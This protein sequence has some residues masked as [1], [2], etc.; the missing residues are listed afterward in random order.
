M[1]GHHPV[2]TLAPNL[3]RWSASNTGVD[4]VHERSGAAP[5]PE[6][7][8]TALVHGNEY[9]GAIALAE[10]LAA[11]WRPARGRVTLAFCNVAAFER[12]EAA[13]PDASR[14]IDEDFNRV[15][16][17]DVLDGSRRSAELDR[18]RQLRPFVDRATHLLDLHSMHEPCTPLLVTG[19][20]ARNIAFAQGLRTASQ[21]VV[22]GGHADGVRMR[23][24]G[25]FS[26]AQ[27][28]RIA[29][30][31]EAGQHWDPRAVSAARDTLMRFLVQ[32]G[33]LARSEVPM[34]WLLPDR[35]PPAPVVVTDRVVAASMDFRFSGSYTGGEVIAKA[36]T[37]IAT[38]AGRN[39][40]TPYDDC[41]LVM[42]SLRQLRPGVT[43][44]RLGRRA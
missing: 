42:P 28:G 35:E 16:A 25:E 4:H 17:S 20:L 41:V 13:R 6:I 40:V 24:Y 1:P 36:G 43:T 32:A 12:F 38:D 21:V 22:D 19:T 27:G 33:A 9:S 10:L 5:G 30:L 31:L 18:A 8:V 34:G 37:V 11:G 23:D 3:A 14:F 29:L 7:L 44:V 15:W 2:H 39:L 26:D